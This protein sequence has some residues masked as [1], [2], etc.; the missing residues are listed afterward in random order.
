MTVRGSNVAEP[1]TDI[2][3]LRIRVSAAEKWG[4]ER[5]REASVVTPIRSILSRRGYSNRSDAALRLAGGERGAAERNVQTT[6][7][8]S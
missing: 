2:L 8:A 3:T 6:G 4:G 1:R 7:R 5:V